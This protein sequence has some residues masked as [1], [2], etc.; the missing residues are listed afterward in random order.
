MSETATQKTNEPEVPVELLNRRPIPLTP[1]AAESMGVDPRGRMEKI[2]RPAPP[3]NRPV[4]AEPLQGLTRAEIEAV[5]SRAYPGAPEMD[6]TLGDKTPDFVN[7]IYK[8]YPK[9]AAVRYYA[10]DVWPTE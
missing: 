4:S 6:G 9:D 1:V 8:N 5:R 2:R 3:V 10:R 7:W